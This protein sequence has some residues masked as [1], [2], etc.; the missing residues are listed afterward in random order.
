MSLSEL[1][2]IFEDGKLTEPEARELVNSM[3]HFEIAR[4]LHSF[5]VEE[6]SRIFE[7]LDSEEKQQ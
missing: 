4:I 5:T 7:L 2:L 1:K 6:K 3:N